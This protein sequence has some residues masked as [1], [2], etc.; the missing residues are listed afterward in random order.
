MVNKMGMVC[1][2]V[3][4]SQRLSMFIREKPIFSLERMLRKEYERKDLVKK[5]FDHELQEAWCQDELVGGKL[6]AVKYF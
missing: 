3:H 2:D 1:F 5:Y 6:P 4:T